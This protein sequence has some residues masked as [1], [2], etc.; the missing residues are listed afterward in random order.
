MDCMPR[1]IVG[2]STTDRWP[3]LINFFTEEHIASCLEG[4][5]DVDV[6]VRDVIGEWRITAGGAQAPG[7]E[8]I[9]YADRETESGRIEFPILQLSHWI[10]R[11]L[12]PSFSRA[13]ALESHRG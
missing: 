12:T 8:G 2:S 3:V 4:A 9:L 1:G 10:V 5:G 7:R 6:A 13:I 11:A